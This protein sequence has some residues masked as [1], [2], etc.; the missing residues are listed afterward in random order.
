MTDIDVEVINASTVIDVDL[1]D[2]AVEVIVN[3]ETSGP[4]GSSGGMQYEIGKGLKVVDNTLV[5]DTAEDVEE[6]NT[7]PVTSA[8]VYTTVGNINALLS[9][10]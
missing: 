5:V 2:A 10:I 1:Y 4:P 9:T 7:L 8:A 3:V 6:D